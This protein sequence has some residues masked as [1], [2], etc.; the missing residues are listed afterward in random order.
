MTSPKRWVVLM[1][2]IVSGGWAVAG[3]PPRP[4]LVVVVSVD[5]WAYEYLERFAE[6]FH[7]QGLVHRVRRSGL[8]Y[9]N[10]LHRHAFT[11]TA[12]GHA[13][14]LTGCYTPEHGILA[15]GWFDPQE[16]KVVYCVSDPKHQLVGAQGP[17]ASPHRLLADTAG[18]QLK[19]ATGGKAKVFGVA[20]KDRAAILMAGRMAD[21]AIWFTG[22]RWVTSTYYRQRPWG[23]LDQFNQQQS[24]QRYAGKEWTLLWSRERY[25]HGPREDSFGERP[26]PWLSADFP[27]RFA[28]AS[29][30][31]RLLG[32]IGLSPAGNELTLQ[33]AQLLV[34]Q[35]DLG[36]DEVPDLLCIN[37]SSPDYVGHA[38]GPESL[39]VEDMAY[40]TDLQLGQFAQFLDEQLGS[41]RWVMF[42]SADHGVAPIPERAQRAGL[43]AGRDPLGRIEK[44]R[45]PKLEAQLEKHLQA[46]LEGWKQ[47]MPPLI[48]VVTPAQV[49]LA[50]EHPLWKDGRKEVARALARDWLLGHPAVAAAA[51][52]EELLRGRG[53]PGVLGLM[54]NAYH[55]RRGGDVLFVLQPYQVYGSAAA[56]HG[57]PWRYDRHVPLLVAFSAN[58]KHKPRRVYRPVSP[59]AIGPTVSHLCRVPRPSMSRE[60]PLQELIHCEP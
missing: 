47:G 8:W 55:P 20:I 2:L 50:Q 49:F 46:H 51:T 26:G 37:L 45:I 4:A 12:V 6:N 14:L 5:Q 32:Q 40:Q 39:E 21:G 31:R 10:C 58:W 53:T 60:E 41:R 15:N 24:W 44:G 18:D 35:E 56:T 30:P 23:W 43:P 36:G 25:V 52:R 13:V 3:Q 42:V 27:H 59:A 16:G 57:S 48:Q 1:V 38:F 9:A 7:P 17:G 28:G 29:D 54:A 22:G 11:V 33:L 19:W 34:V